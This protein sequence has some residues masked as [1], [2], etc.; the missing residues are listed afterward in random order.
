MLSAQ[1]RPVVEATLPVIGAN[2]PEITPLFYKTMFGNHPELLDGMFSRANQK[3]GAQPQALA[4]SIAKFASWL[5]E[6]PDSLPEELLARIA[7]KHTSLNVRE[8]QYQIVHDNLFAAIVEV[9]G[10]AV[11]PEVA[12]AW[13]EVYWLMADALIKM[14]K[15]LYAALPEDTGYTVW[16][17]ASV[18]SD[19]ESVKTFELVPTGSEPVAPG[20]PGHYVSIRMKTKDGLLQPRQFSLSCDPA[21]TEHR[22]ITV[23]RDDAGEISPVMFET[24]AEGSTLEVSPPFGLNALPDDDGRPLV[25]VTAGIGVTVASG[26][27]CALKHAGDQRD[28]TVVHADRS[29]AT[30][31][32]KAQVEG[33][34]EAL[35][36]ARLELFLREGAGEGHHTEKIS[37]KD[38]GVAENA[39]VFLCGPQPFMQAMRGQA[40]ELG[41]NPADIHYDAFGP[42]LWMADPGTPAGA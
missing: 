10:D 40:I 37:L 11:T 19:T 13:D 2:I 6:H 12:A 15:G 9:L 31:A 38:L 35:P 42:D 26:A 41:V 28:I 14:E 22:I 20:K 21:S 18:S 36:N 5:L 30:M 4:G 8:D 32:R 39:H 25:F 34:V 23:K 24:L 16:K 7:H 27:L 33:A 29:E 17:V 3:N 1:S